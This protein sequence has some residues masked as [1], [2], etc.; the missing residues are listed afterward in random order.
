MKHFVFA[1]NGKAPAPA[2]GGKTEAWFMF[3]KWDVDGEAYVP[4]PDYA[5]PQDVTFDEGDVLWFIMDER[6]IGCVPILRVAD[7]SSHDV[8][9]VYYDTRQI[10]R[11]PFQNLT[12]RSAA[13]T[14]L[15]EN[16]LVAT[17]T[18]LKAHFDIAYPPPA[19]G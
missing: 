16:D 17:F 18:E 12:H 11:A 5:L 3:Y 8:V 14:G 4:F 10:Q 15:V 6:V 1:M 19:A 7:S 2:S 13:A 9:E